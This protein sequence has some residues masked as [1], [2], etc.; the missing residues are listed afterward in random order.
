MMDRLRIPQGEA[1]EAGMVSRSIESAQRK[2][3][4]RNFDMRKQLLEY[5]DVGNDQRRVIY[6]Q[7]NDILE[8]GNVTE[9]VSDMRDDVLA[10]TLLQYMPEGS[11]EEQWDLDGLELFLK[12]EWMLAIPVTSWMREHK[13]ASQED[14]L[15]Y[16]QT[17]A[18][19]TYQSKID[20]V[21]ESSFHNFERALMLQTMDNQWRDH[22][23]A[24]DHLRQ[25]IHLRSYAQKNPKQEYKRE[26]FDLFSIMLD[27]IKASVSGVLMSV[28]VHAPDEIEAA[29]QGILHADDH[30]RS[31]LNFEHPQADSE[32]MGN[33][34]A[35]MDEKET[36][37]IQKQLIAQA[38]GDK[39]PDA[40]RIG[41]NE[42]CPCGS[43]KKYKQCHGRI[44]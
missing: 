32:N 4:G 37:E 29:E 27:R 26:S 7:R 34:Y 20:A 31:E 10:Q 35:V 22:L 36:A 18:A 39:D 14:L 5:D 38:F 11:S 12:S 44:A 21:G 3:E 6:A 17:Q 28:Q 15:S 41:R 30:M 13:N 23:A 42:P 1:I 33:T 8:A 24:L 19:Q 9:I 40:A 16:I 43:G 2:V 25:G